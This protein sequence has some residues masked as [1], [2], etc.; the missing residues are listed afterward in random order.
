MQL[1]LSNNPLT[2]IAS[3]LYRGLDLVKL[4]KEKL[5]R[6]KTHVAEAQVTQGQAEAGKKGCCTLL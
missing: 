6:P 4:K 2:D 3:R 5:A 1:N